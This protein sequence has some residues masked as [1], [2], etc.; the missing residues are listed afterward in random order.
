MRIKEP[1]CAGECS[2]ALTFWPQLVSFLWTVNGL[3][4]KG[5][6]RIHLSCSR[7]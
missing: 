1:I 4:K 7:S 2:T 3:L 6:E 5:D